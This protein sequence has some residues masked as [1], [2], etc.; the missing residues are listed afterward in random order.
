MIACNPL[1]FFGTRR[2]IETEEGLSLPDPRREGTV[3][4]VSPPSPRLE[5]LYVCVAPLPKGLSSIEVE[6]GNPT[7]VVQGTRTDSLVVVPVPFSIFV[8][9]VPNDPS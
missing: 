5:R 8:Q 3:L 2:L 9:M 6:D 7:V 4:Y 1:F